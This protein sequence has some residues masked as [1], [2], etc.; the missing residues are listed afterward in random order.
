MH[1]IIFN[2]LMKIQLPTITKCCGLSASISNEINKER[3]KEI[4]TTKKAAM[5]RPETQIIR[6]YISVWDCLCQKWDS[7][8][9]KIQNCGSLK[10]NGKISKT[11]KV[12][13]PLTWKRWTVIFINMKKCLKKSCY[14]YLQDKE[15]PAVFYM[16]L[17]F[18]HKMFLLLLQCSS[19]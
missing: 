18:S 12:S 11:G 17:Y 2:F 19:L 5:S 10:H 3:N 7:T 8:E 15:G 9:S 6:L 13:I 1:N 14:D 4:K 16:K